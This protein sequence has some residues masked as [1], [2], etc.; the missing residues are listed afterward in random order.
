MCGLYGFTTNKEKFLSEEQ[1]DTREKIV[2][3]LAIAMEERGIDS[4]G[5]AFIKD[6]SVSIAKKAV[7]S[8]AFLQEKGVKKILAVRPEIIL[9][10]TRQATSGIVN[11]KNAHPFIKGNIVGAHNGIV[12]NELEID[13]KAEVDSELIFMMLN[14]NK[15]NFK[16]TFKRLSGSFA[17]TWLDITNPHTVYFVIHDN[18]LALVYVSELKTI[19][20]A[21]TERALSVSLVA[22]VGLDGRNI[23]SPKENNVYKINQNLRIDKYKVKFKESRYYTVDYSDYYGSS[24]RRNYPLRDYPLLDDIK[25]KSQDSN[26]DFDASLRDDDKWSEADTIKYSVDNF[27]CERCDKPIRPKHGFWWSP[28]YESIMCKRC[29]VKYG[30]VQGY[31]FYS[32]KNYL[33]LEFEQTEIGGELDE[34]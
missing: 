7:H 5:M 33:D 16:K 15:N 4:S 24:H 9:G 22:T 31:K 20:W 2:K 23:W 8:T 27:G 14:K 26:V 1:K 29:I 28:I 32:Y 3:S 10:H 34:L 18:P 6:N 25:E 13:G 17:I 21:S 11:N 19:F 30:Y 12:S